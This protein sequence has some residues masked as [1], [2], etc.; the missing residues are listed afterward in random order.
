MG[1]VADIPTVQADLVIRDIKMFVSLNKGITE[2]L[3][4][5][6][7]LLKKQVMFQPRI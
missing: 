5:V 4:K 2:G 3:N 7:R 1:H 6:P